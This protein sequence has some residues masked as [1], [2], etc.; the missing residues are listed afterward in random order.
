MTPA[1]VMVVE[2]EAIVAMDIQ[3]KLEGDLL[4]FQLAEEGRPTQVVIDIDA[5][6]FT[7]TW[8]SCVEAAQQAP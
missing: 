8:L 5:A 2:D 3:S 7:E 1:K 4:R 6:D